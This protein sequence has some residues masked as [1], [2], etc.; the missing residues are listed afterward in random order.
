MDT[1]DNPAPTI[2]IPFTMPTSSQIVQQINIILK[3]IKLSHPI[4]LDS[5]YFEKI[6]PYINNFIYLPRLLYIIYD[7][8]GKYTFNMRHREKFVQVL[9]FWIGTHYYKTLEEMDRKNSKEMNSDKI[10]RKNIAQ[11]KTVYEW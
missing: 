4:V 1:N 5:V 7:T 11:L 9:L 8:E 10:E 6:A 2:D 3:D